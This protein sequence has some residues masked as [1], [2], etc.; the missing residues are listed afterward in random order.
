[1]SIDIIVGL[2]HLGE[3]PILARAR[4][5]QQPALIS[6]NGLSRWSIKRGR[7]EWAGWRTRQLQN[8]RGLS[9]LCLDSAGFVA[10]AR[11]GGFPWTIADYVALASA[12]PFRWWASAD[13]CVEQE[14]ARDR[15][16]VDDRLSRTIRA[17]RDCRRLADDFGIA[18]TMMPV[19][20]GRTPSDYER[21]ADALSGMIRPGTLLG[22]GSMCR[23]DVHGPEGLVAVID[24]LDRVLPAGVRLHAFGVK[25]SALPFLRPFAHRVASI[26]SQAYGVGARRAA[27][28]RG[29]SKTDAF[30]ADHME[31][32][33][34]AQRARLSERPVQLTVQ[35][36]PPPRDGPSDAWETAIAQARAE[37][38]DLIEAGDLDHDELTAPWIE[39]WAADIYRDGS[40]P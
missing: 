37:I 21:C 15:E 7:R 12:Y 26:D 11:Y 23:R 9:A 16:E 2:P 18:S 35:R 28:R 38:R 10:A 33:V 27:L 32:W 24:H 39:Q 6:A 19:I 3:G 29:I 40:R 20:Q 8:A 13:Y 1:M 30:V 22:V 36:Q 34:G 4:A 5:L 17:N 31:R 25:G 14:I